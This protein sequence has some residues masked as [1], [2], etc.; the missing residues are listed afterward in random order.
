MKILCQDIQVVEN[1]S[2]LLDILNIE[3]YYVL[4]Q[5]GQ[6][7]TRRSHWL[8]SRKMN[9]DGRKINADGIKSIQNVLKIIKRFVLITLSYHFPL[10]LV[11]GRSLCFPKS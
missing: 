7:Q 11:F 2:Y 4:L 10:S 1:E 8:V 9:A 5:L 3:K 6:V